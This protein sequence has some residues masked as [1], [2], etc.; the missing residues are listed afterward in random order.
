M[1]RSRVVART[2]HHMVSSALH[3]SKLAYPNGKAANDDERR[4]GII[5]GLGNSSIGVLGQ[6]HHSPSTALEPESSKSGKTRLLIKRVM[7]MFLSGMFRRLVVLLSM[8][9]AISA[10]ATQTPKH[11]YIMYLTGYNLISQ[12][13]GI[14]L[15]MTVVNIT[16]CLSHL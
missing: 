9:P 14:R 15:L 12:Y 5:S 1:V 4:T 10:H 16:S 13:I 7:M 11:R 2:V 3:H 8:L 6:P